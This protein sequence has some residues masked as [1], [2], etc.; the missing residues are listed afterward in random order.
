[1]A[2]PQFPDPVKLFIAILWGCPS[3]FQDAL[4]AVQNH[5]GVCDY[6]GADHQFDQTDYYASEMGVVLFRTLIAFKG[7]F[8]SESIGAAK[9]TA[10]AIEQ[11]LATDSKRSV[12]L[13]IGYLDHNKFILASVKYAGH[14]IYI[15][16][17]TY[18]D[19]MGRYKHG[20]YH[21]FEWTF[22]DFRTGRYDEELVAI[23]SLYLH[24]LKE[25]K[26]TSP[27]ECRDVR[28]E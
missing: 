3:R 5:W 18:I 9:L 2:Q 8:A 15:G 23:R 11:T 1:M 17:G 16:K 26:R 21:L 19:L 28:R 4:S 13:D 22:P 27:S 10:N 7:L 14:K 12:N 24:Q 6:R 25:L 20:K